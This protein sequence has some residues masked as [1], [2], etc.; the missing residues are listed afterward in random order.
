VNRRELATR[1][2]PGVKRPA[3][4]LLRNPLLVKEK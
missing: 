4:P 2:A 1:G 3:H